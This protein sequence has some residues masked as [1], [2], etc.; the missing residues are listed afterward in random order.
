M[1]PLRRARPLL[2][3]IVE[4][5]VDGSVDATTAWC[6]IDAAFAAIAG[7]HA[8][9]SFHADDSDVSRINRAGAGTLITVGTQTTEV[10]L[11]SLQL[12]ELSGGLFDVTTAPA[13]CTAGFLPGAAV[14]NGNWRDIQVAG[15]G[16]VR[17]DRPVTID[18]GGIAKGYAVDRAID[19]LSDHGVTATVNAGGDLRRN[20]PG[21]A[22]LHVRRP[23]AP[24]LV[25][26][27]PGWTDAAA[28]SAGYYHADRPDAL[29]PLVDPNRGCCVPTS[30]SVTVFAPTCTIADALTKLVQLDCRRTAAI[31]K[32]Y[33]ARAVILDT[34]DASG[35]CRIY[36]SAGAEPAA[37]VIHG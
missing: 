12:S 3:T 28:T 7:V 6:A 4:I 10:L 19:V 37:E 29:T 27:L 21:A 36:D 31:L 13:L 22:T 24:H 14:A 15:P 1:K 5:S 18:L 11:T 23:D 35:D 9:M 34:D 26:P 2:G 33:D 16:L 30:R 32:R 17:L 25:L 8:R 20:G